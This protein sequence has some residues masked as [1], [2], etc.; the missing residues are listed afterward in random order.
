MTRQT[1]ATDNAP[2]P[3]GPFN[4]GIRV[5]D[6]VFTAGQA[7][8]NRDTGTMGDLAEQTDWA[9]RNIE[10]ILA[11]GG[12]S[13][14]DV[15]KTTVFIKDGTDTSALNAVWMERFSEPRPA[16]SSV[17]VSR[18]KNPEMLIEI[19]AIAVLG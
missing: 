16:R 14:S 17:F 12:A 10:G 4:Q 7:G 2:T 8:R 15:V 3:T 1:I 11:A 5:G 18:L 13:L 19:E 9:L 6:I